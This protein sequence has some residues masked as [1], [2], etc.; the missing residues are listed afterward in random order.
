MIV[1]TLVT[2]VV[3]QLKKKNKMPSWPEETIPIPA[4]NNVELNLTFHCND[5]CPHCITESGPEKEE[6]LDP[7]DANRIINNIK[8][9][10][11]INRLYVLFGSGEFECNEIQIC[12]KLSSSQL[13]P[14]ELTISL[15]EEYSTCLQGKYRTSAWHKGRDKILL[16]F[17]RPSIRLSG[18]EFYMWPYAVSG[19]SV[20]EKDRLEYQSRFL[21]HLRESL[22]EYDIWILTN[23]R[24]AHDQ[25]H[26]DKVIENWAKSQQLYKTKGKIRI[27]ISADIFHQPPRGSTI[28]EMLERIWLSCKKFNLSSPFI[29]GI[30]N[31]RIGYIGRAFQKFT[32]GIIKKS[33]IRNISKSKFNPLTDLIVD[34]IDLIETDGCR[35]VKGFYFSNGSN[36]I[37]A[38][39]IVI[40]PSGRMV[41]CCACLGDYGDFVTSPAICL[42]NMVVHPVSLM[43]RSA[44]TSIDLLNSAVE[45]DPSIKVLGSGEHPAVTAS[46]CYQMMSGKRK[47]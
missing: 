9:F 21:L 29:Y 6:S 40:S 8:E 34:P 15:K 44:K 25:E 22:P 7:D 36:G 13:P 33:K 23:G 32:C 26:T 10:S 45:L 19:E 39:N 43:L 46:T 12:K 4:I 3:E 41:F 30:P 37:I 2:E 1:N 14:K 47:H 42:R 5:H 18:G 35:E 31:N 11:I 24:F 38:N 17:G 28:E 16:N 20:G 27:C